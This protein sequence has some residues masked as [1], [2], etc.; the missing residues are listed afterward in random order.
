MSWE[1][2]DSKVGGENN[3]QGMANKNEQ[4]V[5][6]P[7]CSHANTSQA[8][9]PSTAIELSNLNSINAK[10]KTSQRRSPTIP[11]TTNIAC[12]LCAYYAPTVER[13]TTNSPSCKRTGGKVFHKSSW[14]PRQSAPSGMDWG[15]TWPFSH[16]LRT[17][18]DHGE[19]QLP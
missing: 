9:L 1:L 11:L 15:M 19:K 17:H 3:A 18:V 2:V 16:A 8:T 14:N 4:V 6:S 10:S 12:L 5:S 13:T 7:N